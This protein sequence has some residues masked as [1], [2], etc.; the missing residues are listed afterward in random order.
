VPFVC[1]LI[2]SHLVEAPWTEARRA[3]MVCRDT[4]ARSS[5]FHARRVVSMLREGRPSH[6]GYPGGIASDWPTLIRSGSSIPLASAMA[7]YLDPSP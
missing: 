4:L 2:E 5:G 3:F 1:V 6:E 7:R